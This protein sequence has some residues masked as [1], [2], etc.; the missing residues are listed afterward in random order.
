MDGGNDCTTT[1]TYLTPLNLYLKTIKIAI[2]HGVYFTTIFKE[3]AV[4]RDILK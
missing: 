2:M 1:R 4:A 3:A